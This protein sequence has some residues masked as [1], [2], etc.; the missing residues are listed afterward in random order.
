MSASTCRRV[1]PVRRAIGFATDLATRPRTP[2]SAALPISTAFSCAV[3]TESL[4]RRRAVE[5]HESGPVSQPSEGPAW[6]G[7]GRGCSLP[8]SGPGRDGSS[9]PLPSAFGRDP[10]CA[11][12][13]GWMPPDQPS[14][15]KG[16][17]TER[18]HRCCATRWNGSQRRSCVPIYAVYRSWTHPVPA[19]PSH[20][21]T[22]PHH[23]LA[24]ED[25][26]AL[27]DE[28]GVGGRTTPNRVVAGS[29]VGIDVRT[30]AA[31]QAVCAEA[32]FDQI[33]TESASE[34]VIPVFPAEKVGLTVTEQDVAI[35]TAVHAHLFPDDPR[36]SSARSM[37]CV[38]RLRRTP[39][40]SHESRRS[41]VPSDLRVR[42][43]AGRPRTCDRRIMS[44]LL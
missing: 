10:Q 33:V 7:I 6:W 16:N 22:E 43:G 34:L 28:T 21:V 19:P 31:M 42:R 12:T 9:R 8:V 2:V 24:A 20:P 40:D 15:S 36:R 32:A 38:R 27:I 39:R 41:H 29:I 37:R 11:G 25:R 13:K 1:R 3:I 4:P 44:P 35:H 5:T 26:I 30:T 23:L 17:S 14:D 18:P